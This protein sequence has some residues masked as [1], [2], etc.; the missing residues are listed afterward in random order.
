MERERGREGDKKYYNERRRSNCFFIFS[1][2]S[3]IEQSES[4]MRFVY[5]ACCVSYILNDWSAINVD[6]TADYIKKS[7]VHLEYF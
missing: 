5:C 7:L 4:D 1:F 6:L 2:C 3:T